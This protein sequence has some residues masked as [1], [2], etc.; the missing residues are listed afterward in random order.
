MPMKYMNVKYIDPLYK[1]IC[2]I[3]TKPMLISA[4]VICGVLLLTWIGYMQYQIYHTQQATTD[5]VS[6]SIKNLPAV[7]TV[8]IRSGAGSTSSVAVTKATRDAA[9][10]LS[11]DLTS[12]GIIVVPTKIAT[13]N[14]YDVTLIYLRPGV[15]VTRILSLVH[16]SLV[17]D[18]PPGE[19]PTTA[20]VLIIQA[21]IVTNQKVK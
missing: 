1:K 20:D 9:Q 6:V 2:T 13:Q 8:E 7:S 12:A 16:G 17:A 5:A 21:Q 19:A 4:G 15:N 11:K 14:S 18:L 3:C 10:I